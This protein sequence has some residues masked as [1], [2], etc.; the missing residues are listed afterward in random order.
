MGKKAWV[1]TQTSGSALYK[2]YF[3][4]L[5]KGRQDTPGRNGSPGQ[6]PEKVLGVMPVRYMAGSVLCLEEFDKPIWLRSTW[7]R[8]RKKMHGDFRTIDLTNASDQD[9]F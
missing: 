6:W 1:A 2:T 4:A 5:F 3:S 9:D 7:H 8:S